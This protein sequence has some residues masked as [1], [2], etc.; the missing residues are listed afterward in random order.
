MVEHIENQF[1]RKEYTPKHTAE[2]FEVEKEYFLTPEQTSTIQQQLLRLG[3][4][5]IADEYIED[6]F[7]CPTDITSYDQLEQRSKNSQIIRIRKSTRQKD[8]GSTMI[9]TIF[10]SKQKPDPSMEWNEHNFTKKGDHTKEGDDII[11]AAGFKPY[12]QVAKT[13]SEWQFESCQLSFDHIPEYGTH[14]EIEVQTDRDA[15]PAAKSK[16]QNTAYRLHVPV[17]QKPKRSIMN[18]LASSRFTL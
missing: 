16:I 1:I 2:T 12:Y 4:V 7:Y 8:D 3:G 18:T 14:L 13:R 15:I 10:T 9:E 17:H 6:M 5:H 11:K